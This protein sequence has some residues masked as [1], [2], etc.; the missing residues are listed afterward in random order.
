MVAVGVFISL[1]TGAYAAK[2]QTIG[3]PTNVR[4]IPLHTAVSVSWTAPNSTTG[5]QIDGY[6]VTATRGGSKFTCDAVGTTSCVVSSLVNGENYRL[7]VAAAAR[8]MHGDW[9][10]IG[11]PSPRITVK[12]TAAQNCSYFGN[13]ANLQGCDLTN[14]NLSGVASECDLDRYQPV[15]GLLQRHDSYG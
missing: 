11:K 13:F 12:P 5:Q 1:P 10:P 4:V 3:P 9:V 14:A 8:A 6:I 2:A 7:S 15:A